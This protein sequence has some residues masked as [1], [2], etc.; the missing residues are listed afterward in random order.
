MRGFKIPHVKI[1]MPTGKLRQTSKSLFQIVPLETFL[2]A[3]AALNF[4][5]WGIS[6]HLMKKSN[7]ILKDELQEERASFTFISK[8]R[9]H[10]M[11]LSQCHT[12][13]EKVVGFED[14]FPTFTVIVQATY[15]HLLLLILFFFCKDR[16]HTYISL[17]I[18]I[19]S[20]PALFFIFEVLF[21]LRKGKWQTDT[22]LRQCSKIFY[23]INVSNKAS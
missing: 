6:I 23:E 21:W 15:T 16:E 12:S 9:W 20:F 18:L 7:T 10:S 8:K 5:S 1:Q 19:F 4:L 3:K 14:L 2:P 22:Y 17:F 13:M 11:Q